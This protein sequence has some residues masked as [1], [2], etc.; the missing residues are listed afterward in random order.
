M[1]ITNTIIFAVK[2]LF[3][4]Q[5]RNELR[6][7]YIITYYI[8]LKRQIYKMYFKFTDSKTTVFC[9]PL[10]FDTFDITSLSLKY[11]SEFFWGERQVVLFVAQMSYKGKFIGILTLALKSQ[12]IKFLKFLSDPFS[13]TYDLYTNILYMRCYFNIQ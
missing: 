13:H 10:H 9:F 12:G 6:F 5:W 2:L 7:K 3:P 8:A 11:L 4:I 1:V